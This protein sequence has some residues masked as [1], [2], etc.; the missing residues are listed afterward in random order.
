MPIQA[1]TGGRKKGKGEIS[2]LVRVVAR[3][4]SIRHISQGCGYGLC[5]LLHI[6]QGC[7]QGLC[8]LLLGLCSATC[9]STQAKNP[10]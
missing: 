5:L 6:S 4:S 1:L 3:A 9:I 10:V 8:L 2:M 7:G